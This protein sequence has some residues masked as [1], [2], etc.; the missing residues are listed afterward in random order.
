M[1]RKFTICHIQNETG[2]S[3]VAGRFVVRN[4]STMKYSPRYIMRR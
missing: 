2:K 3:D 1:V 4:R